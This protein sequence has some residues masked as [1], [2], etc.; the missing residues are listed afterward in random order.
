LNINSKDPNPAGSGN[1]CCF[2]ME[3]CLCFTAAEARSRSPFQTLLF[4]GK[5]RKLLASEKAYLRRCT[6]NS[7]CKYSSARQE[8]VHHNF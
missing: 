8:S 2:V 7:P 6:P 4:W 5:R 3:Q 1:E